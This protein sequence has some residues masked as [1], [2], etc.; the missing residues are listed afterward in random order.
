[1]RTELGRSQVEVHVLASA[2]G[3]TTQVWMMKYQCCC[4]D[5][6]DDVGDDTKDCNADDAICMYVVVDGGGID[7]NDHGDD[8]DDDGEDGNDDSDG[9]SE[10][11]L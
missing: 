4:Y 2:T 9:G 11:E 1:M 6:K 3:S 8:S 7:H 10:G 5:D